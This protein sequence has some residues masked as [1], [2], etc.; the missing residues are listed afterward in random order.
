M[1]T[2]C[3][4]PIAPMLKAWRWKAWDH[5]EKNCGIRGRHAAGAA[6]LASLV[7]LDR[8][9][10][11]AGS[12]QL[13]SVR[14]GIE[15][16]I[17]SGGTALVGDP[18]ASARCWPDGPGERMGM[19]GF[20]TGIGRS[21]Q[22]SGVMKKL[23]NLKAAILVNSRPGRRAG[24]SRRTKGKRRSGATRVATTYS[25]RKLRTA[26]ITGIIRRTRRR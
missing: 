23:K 6:E 21:A 18:A 17:R 12:F 7:S 24:L 9:I 8:R 1:A 4:V 16:R 3:N 22:G 14:E 10:V 20:E 13:V 2:N 15:R 11:K 26:G 19:R 5:I 25:R